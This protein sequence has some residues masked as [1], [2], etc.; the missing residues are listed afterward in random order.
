MHSENERELATALLNKYG[1]EVDDYFKL[2]PKDKRYF[3]SSDGQAFLAYGVKY[4]VAACLFDPV[5]KPESINK[6]MTEFKEL[7]EN[8]RLGI[9]FI[10]TTNKYDNI[11]KSVGLKR[12]LVGADALINIDDFLNE[13]V[14]NKYFR[15]IVNRFNKAHYS[16]Q[17]AMPPHKDELIA[18][19]KSISDDWTQLPYHKEWKF[20]TGRFSK[21]Y[22]SGVPLYILRDNNQKAI[23]FANGLPAYR[24][25]TASIDLI[26][27]KRDSLSNSID[28]L[29][30]EIMRSLSKNNGSL[31][32]NIGISP[33]DGQLFA[34]SWVEKAVI[35]FYRS[36]YRFVGFKGL[37]Q[38]KAKYKPEWEP[39]Y[40][41]YSGG[42]L[43][44]VV[45]GLAIFN[46]ML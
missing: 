33:I 44:L 19:L 30:I 3:F 20:L 21:D 32:F 38:F 42:V 43:S 10:Q 40:C 1:G 27:R 34:S 5:G 28:F 18:E 35:A 9:I 24:K 12:I 6:L 17:T 2:W 7:C 25:K 4:R 46:L 37:H 45:K 13:T 36:S 41:Y 39:R 23:A 16:V 31:F 22:F 14:K 15:N 29:F 8:H 26:R 11:Y